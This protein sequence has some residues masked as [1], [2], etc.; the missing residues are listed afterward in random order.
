MF[1]GGTAESKTFA[2]CEVIGANFFSPHEVA[3]DH[4]EFFRFIKHC[5]IKQEVKEEQGGGRTRLSIM[6]GVKKRQKIKKL[7]VKVN[8]VGREKKKSRWWRGELKR[9]N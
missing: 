1:S 2:T 8:F 5:R 9:G 7:F 6:V 3:P 4:V